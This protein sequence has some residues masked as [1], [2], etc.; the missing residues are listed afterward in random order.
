MTCTKR[1]QIGV[2]GLSKRTVL[3]THRGSGRR[4]S[5]NQVA[6]RVRRRRNARELFKAE[7]NAPPIAS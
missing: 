5:P 3:N 6:A 2:S 7:C 1:V 4:V